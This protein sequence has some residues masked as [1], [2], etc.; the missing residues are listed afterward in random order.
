MNVREQ[1]DPRL[2]ELFG[3]D[4]ANTGIRPVVRLPRQGPSGW[5][6]AILAGFAAVLLFFTLESR[7]QTQ[8]QPTVREG[9][10]SQPIFSPEPP[11]L[12][13]PPPP[14]PAPSPQVEAQS[15]PRLAPSPA[16][17]TEPRPVPLPMPQPQVLYRPPPPPLP[18]SPPPQPRTSAGSALVIDTTAGPTGTASAGGA[19]SS[20]AASLPGV[21]SLWGGRVRA[22]ALANRSDTVAQG[23]LIPAILE[24]AFNST[25]P[26][27]ARA[28]VSRNVRGF[29]G[30]KVL[31]P[32]G[33]RLIGEYGAD[34]ASG[35]K[36][37]LIT[38]TRLIRPDGMTIALASPATDTLGR[39]GVEA[40]VNSHFF[41]RFLNAILRTT[42]DVGGAI[43]TRAVTG[44]YVVA[45]PSMVQNSGSSIQSSAPVPTLSVPAGKSISIF[46]ARDLEFPP[47][48]QQ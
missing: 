28:I 29:D 41:S 22:S 13:I 21:S 12:Y 44:P 32:R 46:V 3:L 42:V 20:P 17:K 35:Q 7:R 24:T 14:A 6:I 37:A 36:R 48:T 8:P 2:E 9:L 31:I 5:T 40:H 26:G 45:L 43:A 33:S 38:W 1:G 19:A 11:P 18:M 16:T 23:T 39:G 34:V 25:S 10:P 15:T 30:T 27:L 4:A 47:E